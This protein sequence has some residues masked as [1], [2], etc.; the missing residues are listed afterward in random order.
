MDDRE[1]DK[2]NVRSL[3]DFAVTDFVV[4]PNPVYQS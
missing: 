2:V 4:W 3:L 1:H